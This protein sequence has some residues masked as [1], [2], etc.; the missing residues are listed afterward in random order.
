MVPCGARLGSFPVWSPPLLVEMISE[1]RGI[2]R[3][4]WN[5]LLNHHYELSLPKTTIYFGR[6]PIESV[7]HPLDCQ[8]SRIKRL[9]PWKFLIEEESFEY[10]VRWHY[11]RGVWVETVK[12][13]VTLNYLNRYFWWVN[14]TYIYYS[15]MKYL[16][17]NSNIRTGQNY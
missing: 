7:I 3:K 13:M 16:L 12:S 8:S 2:K 4:Y 14:I 6:M 9:G 11:R 1:R 5:Y 17:P 10:A 15:T